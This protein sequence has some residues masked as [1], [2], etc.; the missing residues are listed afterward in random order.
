MSNEASMETDRSRYCAG[1]ISHNSAVRISYFRGILSSA[2][3][4]DTQERHS[5]VAVGL[6]VDDT[7]TQIARFEESIGIEPNC[8][9]T[10]SCINSPTSTTV[11][12]LAHMLKAFLSYMSSK[13]IFARQLK[14]GVGYHSPQ[15]LRI[16]QEYL[17]AM[18]TLEPGLSEKKAVMVSSVTGT[19][20]NGN[21]VCDPDYWVRNMV[22]PVNFLGA[23]TACSSSAN[24][25]TQYLDGSHLHNVHVDGWLEIGPH[26]TLQGPIKD[27]LKSTSTNGSFCY[28]SALLRN[29]S[30]IHS[31]LTAVGHLHTQ[32]F[33][34]D[35]QKAVSLGCSADSNPVILPNVPSYPFNHS[36]MYWDE[37]Q[38]NQ[39][40]RFR[41]HGNHDFVGTRISESLKHDEVQWKF[42][43]SQEEMPWV[44]DHKVQGAVLYPAGG[45]LVMVL[46]AAKQLVFGRSPVA[47]EVFNVDFPAPIQI[48]PTSEGIELRIH[49]SSTAGARQ[50]EI[51]H[52]FRVFIH[53]A[54][55]S[56][57]K[58]CSGSIRG[59][60]GRTASDVDDGVEDREKI[61]AA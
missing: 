12:G 34:V 28:T 58:V 54:D 31:F 36:T 40:F 33:Y 16:A 25:D 8:T 27:I 51:D 7:K 41:S 5:M 56:D 9:F 19:P 22:S 29:R 20:L 3:E 24:D 49:L 59:D 52:T 15:M 50:G 32:N 44:K 39:N 45:T 53:Q 23:I 37:S 42:H 47:F 13:G 11:S 14:V 61:A 30:A 55:N 21:I 1:H 46:E 43:L 38:S 17:R 6:S 48:P 18:G 4:Q 60:Y 2:L 35:L 26:S 10:V 57:K